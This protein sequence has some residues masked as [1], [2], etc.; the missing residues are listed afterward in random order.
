M[1]IKTI[2]EGE[3]FDVVLHHH[4]RSS[5]GQHLNENHPDVERIKGDT[6]YK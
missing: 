3:H 5:N 6:Q 1:I 4:K 2:Y